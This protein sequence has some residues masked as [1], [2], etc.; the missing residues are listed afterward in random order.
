M[1]R[2]RSRIRLLRD[3]E[4]SP[5]VAEDH[6]ETEAEQ[7][8]PRRPRECIDQARRSLVE[9]MP[10][11]AKA[12]GA[13]AGDGSFSHMKLMVQLLGLEKGGLKPRQKVKR[14]KTLE[15]ILQEQWEKEP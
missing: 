2:K 7:T 9:A 8:R 13:K 12:L 11:A 4:T 3:D 6:I 15:Q 5:A 1:E 10:D 14:E